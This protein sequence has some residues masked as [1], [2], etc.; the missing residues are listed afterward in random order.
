MAVVGIFLAVENPDHHVGVFGL[1]NSN[2]ELFT[3]N[4]LPI[5]HR[6]FTHNGY[7][8]YLPSGE[9]LLPIF[10]NEAA[11]LLIPHRATY[12]VFCVE[13]WILPYGCEFGLVTEEAS[14]SLE[15]G[16]PI[17]DN[18]YHETLGNRK[19]IYIGFPKLEK[20]Y[21]TLFQACGFLCNE[22]SIKIT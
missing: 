21:S 13:D 11:G 17:H 7:S 5:D 22:D 3:R 14:R 19:L 15:W 1:N 8:L 16:Q 6:F 20:F 4:P 2:G 9:W 10:V 12:N 18:L